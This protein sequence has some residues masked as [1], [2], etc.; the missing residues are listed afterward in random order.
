MKTPVPLFMGLCDALVAPWPMVAAAAV[1]AAVVSVCVSAS[2]PS[3]W[4]RILR[5]TFADNAHK[6][7]AEPKGCNANEVIHV[8]LSSRVEFDG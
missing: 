3:S 5:R 4:F 7:E 1:A 8:L 6:P 2:T